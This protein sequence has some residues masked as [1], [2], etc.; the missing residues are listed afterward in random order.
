MGMKENVVK[1]KSFRFAV[2]I[3]RLYQFLVNEKSEYILSTV[4]AEWNFYWC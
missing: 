1:D 4:V 3:V 2:R